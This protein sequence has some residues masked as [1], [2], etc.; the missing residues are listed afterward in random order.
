MRSSEKEDNSIVVEV[1]V[2]ISS[3]SSSSIKSLNGVIFNAQQQIPCED[4]NEFIRIVWGSF[5]AAG[6]AWARDF[7]MLQK[8]CMMT[9]PST[10]ERL[11]CLVSKSVERPE[12]PDMQ[13]LCKR[14]RAT[15]DVSGGLFLLLLWRRL[16]LYN[17]QLAV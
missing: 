6:I 4:D 9:D 2:I 16:G 15:A 1:I 8:A 10:G 5:K 7:C 3:S 13:K 11:F 12:V 14:I 17:Q